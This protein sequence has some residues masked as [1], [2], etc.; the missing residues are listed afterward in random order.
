[1]E[2][3]IFTSPEQY[4]DAD[5]V[6][7]ITGLSPK[8]VRRLSTRG[9]LPACRVSSRCLRW[10]ASSIHAYMRARMGRTV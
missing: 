10:P 8:T 3:A 7:R 4:L 5:Q 6:A 1:M 9:E 2:P